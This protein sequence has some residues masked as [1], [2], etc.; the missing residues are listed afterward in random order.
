[1]TFNPI[2]FNTERKREREG[3]L[4][5]EN[6]QFA[7]NSDVVQGVIFLVICRDTYCLK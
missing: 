5:A 3:F 7:S 1:M 6:E 2:Q 4:S